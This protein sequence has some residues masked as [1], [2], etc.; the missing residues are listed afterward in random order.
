M[1]VTGLIEFYERMTP[2]SVGRCAEFYSQDAWFKDPFNE[3]RGAAAIERIFAHMFKQV[4]SPR[5]VVTSH[6][7]HGSEAM[8]VWQ[9]HYRDG[10]G[11]KAMVR[12]MSHL[13]YRADGL[14]QAHRDYWDPAE[15]LYMK[16]PV[17][18]FVM[19]LLQRKLSA[20]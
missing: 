20:R 17:L 9:L 2:D 19:R 6:L 1:N 11:Q 4:D 14:V 8:L 7:A 10:S 5:F 15:E 3:V 12:G 18:G 13:S 16:V